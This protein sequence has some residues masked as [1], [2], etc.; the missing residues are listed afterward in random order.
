MKIALY[1]E[2]GS[3]QIV[4]TPEN[5]TEKGILEKLTPKSNFTIYKGSFYQCQ[6]GWTR[7]GSD[8]ASTIIR[9]VDE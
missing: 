3:Q 4:L 1:I 2:N 5:S 9:L 8:D 7:Q 6:G